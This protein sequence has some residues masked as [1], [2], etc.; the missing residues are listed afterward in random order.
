M[1]YLIAIALTLCLCGVGWGGTEK[2]IID[3]DDMLSWQTRQKI[4]EYNYQEW[5]KHY[6]RWRQ[7]NEQYWILIPPEQDFIKTKDAP[8]IPKRQVCP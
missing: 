5:V 7:E 1:K 4:E 2:E 3:D 8:V 6:Q